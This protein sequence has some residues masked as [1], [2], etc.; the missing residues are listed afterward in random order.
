MN[1]RL[2]DTAKREVGKFFHGNV[3][4]SV[5]NLHP[6]SDLFPYSETW[7]VNSWDNTWCAAFV[8]WCCINAGYD[9]PVRY[10]SELVT[11]NFAGCRAWDQWAK[12]PEVDCWVDR[13]EKPEIG[14]IVLFDRV[15]ENKEHDHIAIIIDICD[16]LI[17]T[18]EGNF[19]NVSAIV[20]RGYG[21]V[22]GYIRLN[23]RIEND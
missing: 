13:T 3:M 6:I 18:A 2:A 5:T 14:D 17:T 12:L 7:D 15:F 19:N 23:R 10:D 9:M 16:D 8:Y 1:Q 11:C 4:G 20:K 22:R 21:N